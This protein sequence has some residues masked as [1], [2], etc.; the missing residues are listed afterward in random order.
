MQ[1]AE[2][3]VPV[4]VRGRFTYSVEGESRSLIAVGVRVVVEFGKSKKYAAIVSRYPA[5]APE[6]GIAVKELEEVID[7]APVV[8]EKQLELWKWI[9]DYY[10][11]SEGEVMTAALPAGLRMESESLVSLIADPGPMV[12]LS[13][14]ERAVMDALMPAGA[15]SIR[16]LESATGR[17]NVMGTVK[18]LRDKGLVSIG[19]VM[20]SDY[21]PRTESFVR[22]TSAFM[23]EKR[24]HEALDSLHRSRSQSKLLTA[25]LDISAALSAIRL[26]NKSL[27]KKVSRKTL[28]ADAGVSEA[29]LT[30]LR[31]KHI[32]EIYRDDVSRLRPSHISTRSPGP[33]SPA[34]TAAL[35]GIREA[36]SSHGVCLL[37]GVTSS[38]KTEIYIHLIEETLKKGRNV[39]YLLPE[40]ALTTQITSRL[41]MYFGDRM[42]IYHSRL[43]DA[44][45]VEIWRKQLSSSPYPLMVGVRS[46]VLLPMRNPGLV[47]VDEEHDPSYKQ[48]DPAPRYNARDTALILSRLYGAHALLGT[49]TPSVESYYNAVTGKYGLVTLSERYGDGQLPEIKVENVKELRRKKMMS[50]YLSPALLEETRETL[51]SKEQVILFQNRRG[52]ASFLECRDCG[53][54]P[55][56]ERCDVSLTYHKTFGRLICHY[57][58]ASYAVPDRCPKCGGTHLRERGAGTEQIE[59]EVKKTFPGARVARLDL[60]TTR[61]K[62]SY[63]EILSAFRRGDTDILI[64]TQMVA[65]GLDFDRVR[66]VGILDADMAMNLPDFRAA[67]RAYQMMEQVSG[68]A[69]RR[70]KRGIVILQT[71]SPD[72]PVIK[73]VKKHDYPALFSSLLEERHL[74]CF[75]PFC[76]LIYIY[77]RSRFRERA[78]T[79]ARS[80]AAALLPAFGDSLLGPAAPPVARIKGQH[81][82][83]IMI[84]IPKDASF[85]KVRDF[86]LTTSSRIAAEG[87]VSVFFDVDPD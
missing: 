41:S 25:Y 36:F 8:T 12:K 54:I 81:I 58:G 78:D 71:S 30:A 53:W 31:E 61:R 60:D 1:Y 52:Y 66:V 34:Q 7:T 39:L 5:P 35:S 59:E 33:L 50:G 83:S 86:I 77:V 46:S 49:A 6:A 15:L 80:L 4:P 40:I 65:K 84:K 76:R 69:G 70:Q 16:A 10:L 62:G 75:P 85:R 42:G 19:D 82:R 74:F 55:R 57:C 22:L 24:L 26:S 17:R 21:R 47:I 38:G 73:L 2:V 14:S 64:G 87:H 68:R 29:P 48:E 67:E 51:Q 63:E 37:H 32:L 28:L 20:R 18:A 72:D 23:S 3:I 13:E 56:C 11:C 79:A 43:S 9:A 45:R 27:L 44:E